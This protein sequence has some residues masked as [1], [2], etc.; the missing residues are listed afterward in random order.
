LNGFSKNSSALTS[1]SSN[2]TAGDSTTLEPPAS[3]S[4]GPDNGTTSRERSGADS[5]TNGADIVAINDK[6]PVASLDSARCPASLIMSV[7]TGA[8]PSTVLTRRSRF[9]FAEIIACN[10]P[11][12]SASIIGSITFNTGITRGANLT[13][14]SSSTTSTS[15]AISRPLSLPRL[16]RSGPLPGFLLS[17]SRLHP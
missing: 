12:G 1:A 8:A 6:N 9:F 7:S 2:F 13:L 4:A 14:P 10:D 17:L 11:L 5:F 15:S 16:V 3:R